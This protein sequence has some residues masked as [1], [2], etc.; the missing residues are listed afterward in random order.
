MTSL[1]PRSSSSGAES[2]GAL[3][4]PYVELVRS[5]PRKQALA[6]PDQKIRIE[7]AALGRR[8]GNPRRRHAGPRGIRP[9]WGVSPE[10]GRTSIRI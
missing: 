9:T 10:D 3:G 6:D 8:R 7:R 5:S 1:D 4:E 2:A